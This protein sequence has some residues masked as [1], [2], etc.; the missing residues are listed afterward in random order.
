MLSL[1]GRIAEFHPRIWQI[2]WWA[3]HRFRFLLPHD[4]SF[5]ALRHFIRAAPQGLF[6]DIGANDGI[7]A[8]SFRRFDR[9]YRIFSL[10]PNPLLEPKLR[11]IKHS[12]P[13]FDY[14]IAGAGSE[15]GTATFYV[16]RYKNVL[17]H[18]FSSAAMHQVRQGI[19]TVFGNFIADRI[20]LT[21][22][23]SEIVRVDDLALSPTIVKIDTE[24]FEHEVLGGMQKTI[25][26]SRPFI[27]L[28]AAWGDRDRISRFFEARDY[29]V[30]TY[31]TRSDAFTD[32]LET[33]HRNWFAIPTEKPLPF[34]KRT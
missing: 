28:E 16:P 3:A 25:A 29:T 27:M 32:D 17:L 23:K 21:S 30:G 5:H 31:D 12:D 1:A 15:R 6:L 19:R 20:K 9:N 10:E 34:A 2:G 7:S 18:T 13:H 24:G 26:R 4:P 22:V 14:L 8:L 11:Q 33:A